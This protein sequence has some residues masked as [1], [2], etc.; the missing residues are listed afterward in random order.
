MT[1]DLREYLN[2]RFEK[3]SLDHELQQKIRDNVYKRT[4]PCKWESNSY[5]NKSNIKENVFSII[6][7]FKI[8]W[9]NSDQFIKI[10]WKLNMINTCHEILFVIS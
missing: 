9:K 8:V 4:V 1:K 7:N 2:T 10:V 3:N 5:Y 6:H